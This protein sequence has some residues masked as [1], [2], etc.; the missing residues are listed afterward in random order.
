MGFVMI[1][2]KSLAGMAW[3]RHIAVKFASEDTN[4]RE[5]ESRGAF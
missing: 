1:V 2:A 3:E 4:N 5:D